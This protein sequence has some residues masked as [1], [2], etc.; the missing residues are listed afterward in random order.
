MLFQFCLASWIRNTN[1]AWNANY[2][3]R[4]LHNRAK[5]VPE[6]HSNGSAWL[7]GKKI[8]EENKSLTF[9][10]SAEM[11]A[12][13]WPTEINSIIK[14]EWGDLTL[15]YLPRMTGESVWQPGYCR[16]VTKHSGGAGG[17]F[18]FSFQSFGDRKRAS[19]AGER[20]ASARGAEVTRGTKIACSRIPLRKNSKK[21]YD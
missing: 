16:P 13:K 3:E 17:A 4:E 2:F 21:T 7:R 1:P 8:S 12:G 19:G 14:K 10:S 9:F 15:K 6:K 20:I 18:V 5:C 11:K